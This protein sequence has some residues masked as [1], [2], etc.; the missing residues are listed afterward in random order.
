MMTISSTFITL[1]CFIVLNDGSVYWCLTALSAQTGYIL[2][3][4]YE[5]YYVGLGKDKHAI[6]N[7]FIVLPGWS[8]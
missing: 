7:D 6:K 2:P 4:E 5:I 8:E 1:S 3:E